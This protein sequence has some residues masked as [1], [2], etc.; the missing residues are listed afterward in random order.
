MARAPRLVQSAKLRVA[1][2]A[3]RTDEGGLPV[4]GS[5]GR[6][7][8]VSTFAVSKEDGA[9]DGMTIDRCAHGLGSHPCC[10]EAG[11]GAALVLHAA[12]AHRSG[13]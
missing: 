5:E 13:S 9:P 3:R 7:S 10:E 11:A 2:H 12:P 1:L 8:K 6:L 4:K